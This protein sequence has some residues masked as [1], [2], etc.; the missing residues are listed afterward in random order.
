MELIPTIDEPGAIVQPVP[1]PQTREYID[2]IVKLSILR[3]EGKLEL[4]EIVQ[5]LRGRKCLV[6]EPQLS[7]L[8]NMIIPEGSRVLKENG[9][10]YFRDL[11]GE[12]GEFVSETGRDIPE[13]IVYIVRPNLALMKVIAKQI[14]V[15]L[16]SGTVE[17]LTKRNG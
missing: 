12:L 11:K 4:I 14:H 10:Q 15:H 3:D 5:S 7:N 2:N 8:L 13:N 16:K 17:N 1:Q 9:V 6:V